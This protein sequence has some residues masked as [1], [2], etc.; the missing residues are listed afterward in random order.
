L[1][2]NLCL[3]LPRHISLDTRNVAK[4]LNVNALPNI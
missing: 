2:R 3:V 4:S 1:L